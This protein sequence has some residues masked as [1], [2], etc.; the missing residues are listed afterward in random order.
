VN[1]ERKDMPIYNIALT[2]GNDFREL[3]FVTP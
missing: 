2:A 1:L 3:N